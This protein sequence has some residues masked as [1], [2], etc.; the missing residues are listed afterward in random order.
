[1][2]VINDLDMAGIHAGITGHS[3]YKYNFVSALIW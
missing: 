1:M 3:L 2:H